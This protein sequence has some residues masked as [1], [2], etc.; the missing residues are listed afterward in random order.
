MALL[1][2]FNRH[3]IRAEGLLY[4]KQNGALKPQSAEPNG[5]MLARIQYIYYIPSP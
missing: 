4:L 5:Q 1:C 2:H 3:Q